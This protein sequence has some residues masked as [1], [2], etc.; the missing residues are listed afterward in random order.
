M[1]NSFFSTTVNNKVALVFLGSSNN[2]NLFERVLFEIDAD[3]RQKGVKPFSDLSKFSD[4]PEEEILMMAGSIFSIN[5]IYSDEHQIWHIEMNLCS[6]N[7]RDLK[8]VFNHMRN[9]YSLNNTQLLLFGNVLID[10]ANF[11]DAEKYLSRLLKQLSLQHKDIYKCYHALGKISCEKGNYNLS[12]NY[13]QKSIQILE[14]QDFHDYRIGYVYNS[15]GETYQKKGDVKQALAA[16][17]KALNIFKQRFDENDENIAWSYNNLGII[18][19]DANDYVKA[20]DY[21]NK[22]L[23]IKKKLLP[24]QHPCL[25]NTYNNIGNVYYHLQEYDQALE[26]Y[27]FSYQIFNKS[28]TPTHP[29][30]ARLLKN[31]GIVY[32]AKGE[33]GEAKRNYEKANSIWKKVLSSSHPDSIEIN[34]HIARVSSKIK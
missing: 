34:E 9:Q 15:M 5:R 30:K 20:F 4:F 12:L 28:L 27:Q 32:E 14:Q 13:L 25:S 18:Y 29:S 31:M 6:D 33:F 10:M 26:K 1:R 23:N 7:D 24:A 3:P 17:E 19:Q 22:A 8:A 21:L 11:D 16:Y 2:D